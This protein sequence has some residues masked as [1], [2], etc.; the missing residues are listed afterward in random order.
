MDLHF[1]LRRLFVSTALVG[2]GVLLPFKRSGWG[3]LVGMAVS[4]VY[5]VVVFVRG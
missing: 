3:A 1:S 2:A 5:L 4:V